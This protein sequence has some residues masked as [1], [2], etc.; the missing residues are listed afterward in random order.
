MPV[1]PASDHTRN[2]ASSRRSRKFAVVRVLADLEC[3]FKLTPDHERVYDMVHLTDEEHAAE[4]GLSA[5]DR[6]HGDDAAGGVDDPRAGRSLP[7]AYARS[8]RGAGKN[9]RGAEALPLV[10]W[11]SK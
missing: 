7:P 5:D 1:D 6:G 2:I 9:G 8:V 4:H 11:H 3:Y 10:A